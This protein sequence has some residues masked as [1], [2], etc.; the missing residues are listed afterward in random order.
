MENIRRDTDQHIATASEGATFVRKYI[1]EL[2]R[3]LSEVSVD[4]MAQTL[5]IL[6]IALLER[7]RVFLVGN[8]GSAS[9]ASHMAN[10]LMKGVAQD[11]GL[12][13]VAI[14]LTDN[15]PL[16][17]A[18][19]NDESYAQVFARQLEGQAQVGDVLVVISGSGN[20]PSVVRAVEVARKM[21]LSTIGLL[22]KG[23]GEIAGLVDLA[24]IVPSDDYG[25]IEDIHLTFNHLATAFL[26]QRSAAMARK[27]HQ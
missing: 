18:I 6:E 4:E 14:A 17:T 21:Q 19:G 3:V 23:G 5:A 9:T 26:R 12:G 11:G 22:G 27:D 24:I 25:P 20:S 2:C 1:A 10:D 13:L 7:R 8:G 15:V 16:I